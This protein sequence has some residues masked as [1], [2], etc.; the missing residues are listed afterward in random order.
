MRK[1]YYVVWKGR[2][3]GI[4]DNWKDC[5]RQVKGFPGEEYKSFPTLSE[6][7]A[8]YSKRASGESK[9][10]A[11][12]PDKGLSL[13]IKD[14]A[15]IEVDVKIF[16]DGASIPN[17]GEAASGISIYRGSQLSELWYG[18]YHPVGTNNTAELKGLYHALIAAKAEL[19]KGRSVAI[20]CDSSYSI[21]SVTK[22]AD[23][24]KKKK[25]KKDGKEIKNLDLI[26]PMHSLYE[27][28]KDAINIH[29]VNGHVGIEGNELADRMCVLAIETQEEDLKLFTEPL[30][31]QKILSM[32][33]G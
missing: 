19:L 25:W 5:E 7:E 28:L 26:V 11:L 30:D 2:E 14:I 1:K 33:S 23:G 4:F 22:W 12:A 15:A 9:A 17:P 3:E 21:N 32:K 24:W 6:A 20:F 8:A 16:S 29:H 13:T 31:I 18:L 27:E 10:K